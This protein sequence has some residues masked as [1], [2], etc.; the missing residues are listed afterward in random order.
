L[1]RRHTLNAA[2]AVALAGALAL[3]A[4]GGAPRIEREFLVFG[5]TAELSLRG[6]GDLAAA[7]DA[8]ERLLGGFDAEWHPWRDS[9]L[10]RL[11]AALSAGTPAEAPPSILGLIEASRPLVA[12]S[13][14][15]F[16]PAAGALFAA[17][18]FHTSEWPARAAV[19]ATWV[20]A[21]PRIRPRFGSL[22]IDG[23]RVSAAD[24]GIALDFNAIAEGVAAREALAMLRARGM[25]HALLDLGGDVAALGDAGGRAWR[26]A[27]RDPRGGTLGWVALR[28]GE[29]LF[30]SGSYAKFRD[31]G[32]ARRPHVVD[33][34]SGQPVAGSAAS[35]VLSRDLPRADAA[36]TALMVGGRDD[37]ARLA[38]DLRLGCVLLLTDDDEL[39]LSA[40][41]RARLT[42]LRRPAREV[43]LPGR[44][45]C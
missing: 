35:A 14:G 6:D 36:A 42:L 11:N 19:D 17:W 9:A 15:R 21:W 34:R 25:R 12:E 10:T 38:D 22:R 33:P 45:A 37:V 23:A 30:A 1:D 16:D 5:T 44:P 40:G 2:R 41:M 39:V 43:V 27:L 18:G 29:G 24:R 31:D 8:V 32:G 4:C 7:A 26:V 28:D 13:G 20:E 3:C